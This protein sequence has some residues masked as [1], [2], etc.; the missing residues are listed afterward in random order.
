MP[1]DLA[2]WF[3]TV[4]MQDNDPHA[5]MSS[6]G[7]ALL[8]DNITTSDELGLLSLPPLK[9]G[10]LES[11]ISLSEDLPKQDSVFTGVV[12][13]IVDILRNLLNNDADALSQHV[14]VNEKAIDEY[15][16]GWSWNGQKYRVDRS[17]REMTEMLNKV[18][19]YRQR[20]LILR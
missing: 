9:T 2:Y 6:L 19:A 13:K 1:S 12:A 17:L 14:Q 11:L 7:R 18:R 10:T 20:Q 4:P 16:L 8:K 3:I 5:M 15:I